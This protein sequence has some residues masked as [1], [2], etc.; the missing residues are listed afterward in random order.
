MPLQ[1]R[2]ADT[3][4]EFFNAGQ[5]AAEEPTLKLARGQVARRTWEKVSQ[6]MNNIAYDVALGGAECHVLESLAATA[7]EL[8]VRFQQYEAW[9]TRV[10]LMSRKFNPN[11]CAGE[12]FSL[13]S[14]CSEDLDAGFTRL[15][16]DD[17]VRN[18]ACIED[19]VAFLLPRTTVEAS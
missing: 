6:V 19:Q 4:E 17:A 15:L 8:Q 10:A 9:P 14:A 7:G 11:G 16:R 12:A 18:R 3:S 1:G 13:I 5:A 2:Q